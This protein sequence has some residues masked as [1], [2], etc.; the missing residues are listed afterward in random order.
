VFYCVYQQPAGH[1]IKVE[2]LG[3]EP[4]HRFKARHTF[5]PIKQTKNGTAAYITDTNGKSKDSP[6]NSPQPLLADGARD[7]RLKSWMLNYSLHAAATFLL[8]N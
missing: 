8:H 3:I 2:Q 1:N 6:K 4:Y 7:V 5:Q